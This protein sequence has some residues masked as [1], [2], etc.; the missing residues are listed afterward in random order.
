MYSLN[1][2]RPHIWHVEMD[3]C[4]ELGMTFIRAT[5]FYESANP[6]F[7]GELGW[8]LH[9]QMK[10]YSTAEKSGRTGKYGAF[11]YLSDW[12]GYNVP[13]RCFEELYPRDLGYY[14]EHIVD[15]NDY[16][17]RMFSFLREIRK[18]EPGDSYYLIGTMKDDEKGT[19]GHELAHGYFATDRSYRAVMQRILGS[20]YHEH[21]AC[22]L[23]KEI[24]ELG[25]CE[26]VLLDE[27]QAYCATGF[28]AAF[29]HLIH[30]D[31]VKELIA[32]VG[33]VFAKWEKNHNG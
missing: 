20:S 18:E 24:L 10:W 2:V 31:G 23:Q 11:T 33:Q 27:A 8:T 17:D 15:W 16:D 4:F 28:P 21:A 14:V 19:F 6:E 13:G 29:S 26:D 1:K 7:R 32:A 22:I 12:G 25:Y 9:D 5:E 3:C 30:N